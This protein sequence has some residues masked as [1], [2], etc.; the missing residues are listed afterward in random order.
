MD[1]KTILW[2]LNKD[3]TNYVRQQLDGELRRSFIN[4]LRWPVVVTFVAPVLYFAANYY[5]VG[6]DLAGIVRPS[7]ALF[8][9]GVAICAAIILGWILVTFRRRAANRAQQY[10]VEFSP[11][12]IIIGGVKIWLVIWN[13]SVE[14]ADQGGQAVV[15]LEFSRT[16]TSNQYS[17]FYQHIY[18][19]PVPEAHYEEIDSMIDLC[20]LDIV[21]DYRI[22][23]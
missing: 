14:I 22:K 20:G 11:K 19:V 7:I 6:V 23:R 12:W 21:S 9:I 18:Y 10:V 15:R 13:R 2:Q 4:I 8:G 16:G 17:Y 5:W 3:E 1:E